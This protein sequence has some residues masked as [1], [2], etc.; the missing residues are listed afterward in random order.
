MTVMR[1][2]KNSSNNITALSI[3]QSFATIGF[4]LASGGGLFV[5]ATTPTPQSPEARLAQTAFLKAKE[6]HENELIVAR[7]RMASDHQVSKNVPLEKPR[8]NADEELDKAIKIAPSRRDPDAVGVK[9][10]KALKLRPR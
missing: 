10:E 5:S 3:R 1:D 9:T 8:L 4:L 7:A 2:Y 6:E